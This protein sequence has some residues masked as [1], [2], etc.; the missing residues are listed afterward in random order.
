MGVHLAKRAKA[1]AQVELAGLDRRSHSSRTGP[2][3][4]LRSRKSATLSR[5]LLIGAVA[6]VA[7]MFAIGHQSAVLSDPS[8]GF[9]DDVPSTTP[10]NLGD[11]DLTELVYGD[12]AEALALIQPPKASVDGGASLAHPLPVPPGRADVQPDLALTYDSNSGS[13]WV[14]TGWDLSVG[15]VTV[16]TEFGAPRYL[17]DKESE[18]YLLNG[19]RLFPNAIRTVLEDRS[20][21]P[22]ADWVRQIEDDHDLIIRHGSTPSSYCWEVVDTE[23]NHFW[24]GGT[25]DLNGNCVRD[26]SAILTAMPT[27]IAGG[28]AG[29]YHWALTYVE[30]ISGNIMRFSYE[31]QVDVPIGQASTAPIGVS[32]YLREIRYT[33][34][35]TDPDV[36][37]EPAY[38][39]KFLRDVDVPGPTAPRLDVVVDAGAGAPVVTRDLLRGVEVYYLGPDYYSAAASPQLVKGWTLEYQNG[40]FDK[41]LLTRIGQYGTG[42]RGTEHAWHSFTWFDDVTDPTTGNY[43]GFSDPEQWGNRTNTDRVNI[44]AESAIGTSWRAGAEGGAYIG[45]NPIYPS[46]NGSFGG[47]FNIA[48]GQMNEVSILVDLDG[49]SLP[50]KVWVNSGGTVMYRPNLHRPGAVK[51]GDS[52]FGPAQTITGIDSLG[53]SSDL[54]INIHFEAYPVVAIQVG[55][56]FG[57]SFG[58]RYFEDVNGDGRVDFIKPGAAG[59][60][61]VFYNVLNNGIPTFIDSSLSAQLFDKLEVPLDAFNSTLANAPGEGVEDLLVNTSPR[62][63]TV[64]RWLAPHDGVIRVAGT[65]RLVA[66]AGYRGDGAQVTIEHNGSQNWNNIL[67]ASTPNRSHSIE[68]NVSAG[69]PVWFRLHVIDN[70]ADDAVSWDPIITYLDGPGGSPLS[71]PL[72]ANGRS[73]VRYDALNDFTLFGR[74]GARTALSEAGALTVNVTVETLAGLSDNL[75]IVVLHGRGTGTPTEHHILTVPQLS[76]GSASGSANLTVTAPTTNNGDDGQPNTDDDFEESDWLELH[77]RSDSPIDPTDFSIEITTDFTADDPDYEA[78]DPSSI[79]AEAGEISVDIP[80]VPNVQLFSRTDHTAPYQ[81]VTSPDQSRMQAATIEVALD[82]SPLGDTSVS[83]SAVLTVKELNGGVAA[84]QAF[85]VEHVGP[86]PF[87]RLQGSTTLTSFTPERNTTYYIEVSVANPVVG[88][89]VN[90]VTSSVTWNWVE[91]EKDSNNN[92]NIDVNKSQVVNNAGQL[93]WPDVDGLFP[94]ANRGWAYA[95]YNADHADANGGAALVE[96]QFVFKAETSGFDED[97]PVPSASEAPSAGEVKNGVETS[98]DPAIPYIPW[99]GPTSD[100]AD[101]WRAAEKETLSVTRIVDPTGT[102]MQTTMQADR[103]GADTP[104][105]GLAPTGR[106]APQML[107]LDGDFHFMLGLVASFTAGVGG[108][109]DLK[110]YEDFNGDGLPDIRNG[111]SIEFTGPRGGNAGTTNSGSDSFNLGLAVGG[112]INGSAISVSST[113]GTSRNDDG[114]ANNVEPTTTQSSRGMKLGLGFSIDSQWSNPLANGEAYDAI[115]GGGANAPDIQAD[116][117]AER[118]G[119]VIDR[120]YID[121]NGDG[122]PDRVETF[123]SGEMW[124]NLNLGY[125]FDTEAIKW[126]TGRTSYNKNLSGSISVGFQINAYEFGGG[127]AYTEGVGYSLFDWMDIDGDGVPDRMN[128]VEDGQPRTVFGSGDGMLR[129]EVVYGTYP[130]GD[131][132][133]DAARFGSNGIS[134][135]AGQMEVSRSTGLSGGVDFTISIGP[136]CLVACYIIINPGVHGGYDRMTS[137]VQMMDMN[138]DGYLDAVRSTDPEHVEVRLN[139]RG[140]TNMLQSVINPLGGVIRLDYERTGNTIINPESVWVMSSVEVDDGRAGDGPSTQRSEF[141]YGGNAYDPLLRELLGFS[142]IREDQLDENGVVQRS[143]ERDYLNGNP[144]E[145]GTLTEE[146]TLDA[147]GNVVRVASF[148]WA[149]VNADPIARANGAYGSVVSSLPEVGETARTLLFDTAISPR[150]LTDTLTQFDS[151]GQSQVVTT[152]YTYDVIGNVVTVHDENE[153]EIDADDTF[154]VITYSDCAPRGGDRLTAVAGS[155]V[156][157]PQTVTVYGNDAPTGERLKY[158]HGGPDLCLNATPIRI[159]ELVA[160]DP[161]CGDLYA[162]TELSFDARGSYDAV[163]H[164]SNTVP[165]SCADYP[166]ETVASGFSFGGCSSLSPADDATRHCVDYIYDTHRFTAIGQVTDN[167]GVTA[168]A[169]YDPNTGRLSSRTDENGNVTTYTYDAVGRLASIT[170]PREQGGGTPTLAYAYGGLT[171]TFDPSG[172]HA[173]A[174]ADHYDSFNPGNTI[175]TV[176]FVDGMG[177]V[178]QRKRDAE[179][180]GVTGEARIV[181]GA[182]EYDALGREIKEWYPVVETNADFALTQYNTWNSETGQATTNV[183]LTQPIARTY[184]V[185]DRMRSQ[186]LPDNSTETITYDFEVLPDPGGVYT[187]PITMSR[188]RTTDALGKLTTRYLDVGGAVFLRTESPIGANDPDGGADPLAALPTGDVFGAPRVKDSTGTPGSITTAYEYDRLGRLT[189]VVDTFGA[190]T[191]HTYNTLDI[192]TSTET[193]DSGLVQRTFSP[194]GQLLTMQR[195]VGTVTSYSYDRDRIVGVDYS[196]DT[197]DVSFQYGN[198]GAAENAA[199]RVTRVVDGSMDRTY[200]YDVDGNVSRETAKQ[201]EDPFGKGVNDSPPTWTTQ[202]Q[203]DSL[204]RVDVLIYPDGEALAHEYDF[205][206]RPSRLESQ[207]PQHDLYDQYG[208]PVPRPDATIIYVDEVQYDQFGEPTYMR[209]GTGIETR[210]EREPT[211]RF[212][213]GIDTDATASLQY[214]GSTSAARP[215]QRL[216]Y[217]YDAVGNIRD[218]LNALYADGT[219]TAITEVGPAPV[220]N[221]P[222]PSQHAFTYDGHYRLT[223]G[224]GTYIDQKEIRGFTYEADYDDNG[225]L[226]EKRQVTTTTSTTGKGK[227]GGGG[228]DGSCKGK[229]CD[230]GDTGNDTTGERT[231]ESNTGSGGGSFNQDPETTYVIAAGDL[232][233]ATDLVGNTIHQLIRS[234]S[235]TYT[236][237]ANGNMTGWV[238]PCSNG[239]ADISRTLE[240]DAEN[241]LTRIAEDNNDT[242][243]RYS[244][245]GARTLESGPGGTTWF[246]NEHWRTVNDGHRYANIYIGEQLIASHRT[247]S[248]SPP[249]PP[250]P[251]TDTLDDPCLCDEGGA[252]V[253]T[254]ASECDL[255][256][257][258]FDPATST[259]QPKESRTVHFLHKDLQGSLRVAT[260]EVG[261]VFQYVDYLPT[262]RPWVAGQSTI[263]DTPYLFAGGWTDTTYDLVNFGERWYDPR[264]ENFL[265]PEPLLEEEPYAVV[266]AP[267][268]LSAY[269]YAS[270]NPLR[271]V[272]PDGRVDRLASTGFNLGQN[273]EKHQAGDVTISPSQRANRESPAITFGGRYSNDAKGQALGDAFKKH[274]DRA[275]RFST[276]LS[277][278]TENGETTVRIFGGKVPPDPGPGD[279]GADNDDA[280]MNQVAPVGNPAQPDAQPAAQQGAGD[281]RGDADGQGDADGPGDAGAAA[282]PPDA[283]GDGEDAPAPDPPP[284]PDPAPAAPSA[285]GPDSLE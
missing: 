186:V 157:V 231:C 96:S 85:N 92:N 6:L 216:E 128:N 91:T 265:S 98:F 224:A 113:G 41:S 233:Y 80:I 26:E 211:R 93:H 173:W 199:G 258:I 107:G 272:D 38:L 78:P 242:E 170:A 121:V 120:A 42:G 172:P 1:S 183:P 207:T 184:D 225:N 90:L 33:G 46:K 124:V 268:I 180:D 276:I 203:Y 181:E 146:R 149:F 129:S 283:G 59:G 234:G 126:S 145:T 13:G 136:V 37:D 257:Q 208:N 63:D 182:I 139:N 48:G 250:P 248:S 74:T 29:D 148:E 262:G 135:P 177:R 158:R 168:S 11:L 23:G 65:A 253:V 137:Q 117:A 215:L 17:A 25:P 241:R 221:V 204:G 237:D 118:G 12:P 277:I 214:D 112:G 187:A 274:A 223:E 97:T 103:L 197:P 123:T 16:D 239:N 79:P 219:E 206:G 55:G 266:D 271:F 52:W 53:R 143:F 106:Q 284:P 174:T 66:G 260:D 256:R 156:S 7:A 4:R 28:V 201:D 99:P 175:D 261:K 111:G 162:I 114:G 230:E 100:V 245:E 108:G 75:E 160:E 196:D 264:E 270:S 64:R 178:V 51:T 154:T 57:F 176:S 81:P 142:S 236:Y 190:R 152:H 285:D 34:F 195:A 82:G 9:I 27:G 212:L 280:I 138:G 70:A 165:A 269:T 247:S 229:K 5:K 185:Y 49:D 87:T 267:S 246:V 101:R 222:G 77:V 218:A 83:S 161:V 198:S 43:V 188:V 153:D 263:K 254:D 192:V 73:Q 50:D 68:L 31:E 115:S 20:P 45:F 217:T 88:A 147:N 19:Q 159:A 54:K 134:L 244:A 89:S 210:W 202:W 193:P 2:G 228:K 133:V 235:R 220:N 151:D 69:D 60:H 169:T 227:G 21:G 36:P 249:L 40:P 251:C 171:T 56:G 102:P 189:A 125:R 209:T 72:D 95:G 131:V 166:P 67:N 179:V 282:P 132:T 39:V 10:A 122:L 144:F 243:Y 150:L 141:T 76:V 22:R 164:P 109:R 71:A 255:T 226:L 273:F 30:D 279:T 18:T 86:L 155:W 163:A 127:V 259:C 94:S 281:G 200:G 252:C 205:G 104:I 130:N 24:Y 58:D 232:E 116:L 238:Q 47:S 15:E 213:A 167:H 119:T 8:E 84:R 191:E 32:L 240:W 194:S 110:D 140:R 278:S 3:A 44:A 61:T 35:R 275:E 14:G 62:I 105:P